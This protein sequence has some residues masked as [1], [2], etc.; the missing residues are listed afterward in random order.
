MLLLVC[1]GLIWGTIGVCGRM[2]FSRSNLDPVEVSWLRTL[3]AA[4]FCLLIG[5]QS[6]GRDLFRVRPRDF[7]LIAVFALNIFVYQF[8]YLIGV[9]DVGI[10]IATLLCLCSIP[11]LVSIYSV[12]VQGE[13]LTRPV[14][15]ALIGAVLGTALLTLGGGGKAG[16]GHVAIGV[17]AALLSAVGA[18]AYNL[19]SQWLVRRYPPITALA[20]GFPVTLIVFAP[21][22]RGGH[23]STDLPWS[24]WLIL[25]YMGVGTQGIAYLFFQWGVKTES[26]TVAS[27][28]TLL[29]P[30]VASA[31]AWAAFGEQLG[32]AGLIGALL[33]ISGLVLLTLSPPH[34]AAAGEAALV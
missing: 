33:L 31:I 34:P 6:L 28:V 20:L 27:I 7:I 19:G 26:A 29:E 17:A 13:I 15:F 8:L 5:Y 14:L 12:V 22:M 24:V 32:A 10:S 9:R 18:S 1:T 4:P 30:V 21:V 25:L 3:F 2:I 16:N 11:V 23:V